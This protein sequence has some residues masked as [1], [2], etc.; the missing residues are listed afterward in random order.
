MRPCLPSTRQP[1]ELRRSPSALLARELQ[2]VGVM[3]GTSWMM[4]QLEYATR[5][6]HMAADAG[7]IALLAGPL[8]RE[9]YE[10]YLTKVYAFEAPIEARWQKIEGFESIIDIRPRLRAGFL[11]T[12]LTTLG[13][14]AEHPA[15]A[16]FVGVEQALGW[17]YVVERGRRM[18]A[19]LHRHLIRRIPQVMT[20]AG[21]YL[22]ASS[23]CGARWQ[24]FGDALDRFANNHVIVEQLINA[25]HHAFRFQKV[26]SR[27]A[28]TAD[29]A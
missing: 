14:R 22:N 8:T 21:N 13:A 19:L 27:M 18:N 26:P 6:H 23:P 25:A 7:R 2:T 4:S 9:R 16:T 10:D 3:R 17:M 15:A 28:A 20:L 1:V 24:Q 12:D 5:D 29:A 11:V